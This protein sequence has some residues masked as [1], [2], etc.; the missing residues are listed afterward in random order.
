MKPE[1][2]EGSGTAASWLARA[3]LNWVNSDW[4]ALLK[5]AE[6]VLPSGSLAVLST[7]SPSGPK[8]FG[9]SRA[10]LSDVCAAAPD[11]HERTSPTANGMSFL[12]MHPP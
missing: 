4:K 8:R 2:G 6:C 10:S 9:I 7:L 12:D 11:A 1:A 5:C 3:M